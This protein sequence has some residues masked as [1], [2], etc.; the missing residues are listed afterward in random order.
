MPRSK[1][2]SLLVVALMITAGIFSGC[3]S[4]A[5]TIAPTTAPAQTTASTPE[6]VETEEPAL[7]PF[8]DTVKFTVFTSV[9]AQLAQE[10]SE[11]EKELDRILNTDIT[12][13]KVP[14]TNYSEKLTALLAS[15]NLPEV[16]I[17]GPMD[18]LVSQ[19]AIIPLDDKLGDMPIMTAF[20]DKY[21]ADNDINIYSYIRYAVD[22]K[23]YSLPE[24]TGTKVAYALSIRQDWLDKLNLQ[25]P[26]TT[27]D[28]KNVLA[29]FRDGNPNGDG[30][31]VIPFSGYMGW[32]FSAYGIRTN[33][34]SHTG[35]YATNGST[36]AYFVIDNGK[37]IPIFE[38]P[39]YKEALQYLADLYANKLIDQEYL[40]TNKS[41]NNR[42]ELWSNGTSGSGY[43]YSS[44]D[45]QIATQALQKVDPSKKMVGAPVP[46]GPYGDQLLPARRPIWA[47]MHI[48]P[49]AEKNGN[50]KQILQFMDW[51]YSEDGIR[52]FSFGVEGK[53]YT[54]KDGK[55]VY[56]DP[57][58]KGWV[59]KRAF[60]IDNY[61]C[62][63]LDPDSYRQSLMGG[64]ATPEEMTIDSAL[65]YHALYDNEKYL[66]IVPPS[67]STASSAELG[68][69]VFAKLDENVDK[70]IMG[71]MTM[72]QF[73]T[74]YQQIKTDG[75][76]KIADEMAA[77]YD[78]VNAQ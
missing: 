5:P 72:D 28:W 42:N 23:L 74:E 8:K 27:D 41:D 50:L 76:Q 64:V 54:M 11:V 59:D 1:V 34:L 31:P 17:G 43:G 25:M 30:K 15:N 14:D 9:Y 20:L 65:N 6:P 69:T 33:S 16:I 75:F 66:Y 55:P 58:G 45:V 24:I 4:A 22:G 71:S 73:F 12:Y 21:N 70:V 19:D 49:A 29:A 51:G 35:T 61:A 48:T 53:S 2:L 62:Y 37:Y 13:V 52:L 46:V 56:I 7:Y 36:D 67:F 40:V 3:Q 78:K 32:A 18:M 44:N 63:F 26:K 60:G 39:H 68:A 57:Y 47:S 10:K 77:A 38:H